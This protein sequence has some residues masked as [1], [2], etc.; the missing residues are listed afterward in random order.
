MQTATKT[1]NNLQFTLKKLHFVPYNLFGAKYGVICICK[2]LSWER[3][4]ERNLIEKINHKLHGF[5]SYHRY[6]HS[7]DTFTRMDLAI[8]AMLL[9]K[10]LN[11]CWQDD[12]KNVLDTYWYEE[13]RVKY[14]SLPDDCSVRLNRLS[15]TVS[16]RHKKIKL[17]YNP[18]LDS[19][20]CMEERVQKRDINNINGKYLPVWRRQNGCCFYCKRS[21]LSY[22]KRLLIPLDLSRDLSVHNAAYIHGICEYEGGRHSKAYSFDEDAL[23]EETVQMISAHDTKKK[24]IPAKWR[25]YKLKEY[26]SHCTK[27]KITL[28]FMQIEK[29]EGKLL[30]KTAYKQKYWWYPSKTSCMICEAW[31][32]EG[33]ELHSLLIPKKL[34][35]K[36]PENAKYELEEFME[37]II[38][39]YGL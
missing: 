38:K 22:Q 19:D 7:M 20:G 30:P 26:F 23:Y 2:I 3:N 5:A 39:K 11:K 18:F 6:A 25:H 29:I 21:I 14:F 10:Y 12:K 34:Q 33:Y 28:T 37:Y 32:T 4:T 16:I 13:G 15:D 35:G 27:A 31:I 17:D 9:Q 36:I 8:D 24:P 1:C